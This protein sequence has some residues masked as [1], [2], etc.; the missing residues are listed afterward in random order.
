[1]H[2]L[3]SPEGVITYLKGTRFA[4]S[5]VHRL[6]GGVSAF[7]YRVLLEAPLDTGE[8]T[9]VIKHFEGYLANHEEMKWGIERADHEYKALAAI[10]NSGLFDSDSIVQLPRPLKYDQETHT[11]F[12]TDLGSPIPLTQVLEKGFPKNQTSVSTEPNKSPG[13][14]ELYKL[15]AEI[16]QALGDFLGRFHTW[17][18]LPQQTELRAYF[19]ENPGV[20]HKSLLFHHFCFN[21]SVDRFKIRE[22][23]M[24]G[25]LA[26]EQQ[27]LE[28]STD[29]GAMIMGDCSLHNILVSPPS[30][31]SPMRIYL[32]DLE[33]ARAG[34]P[35][36]D[37]GVLTAT[38]TSFALIYHPNINHPF[39][40]A[41]H[42][43]YRQHRTLDPRRL[44]ITTGID[45]LG[46]GTFMPWTRGRDEE[47][48]RDVA[49]AGF[50]LLNSS[51]TSD[52]HIITAN[53]IVQHLFSPQS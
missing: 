14:E 8:H 22:A 30:E 33:T 11:I 52:Q 9:I 32:I 45:L 44:G 21:F 43:S 17:S 10:N 47:S 18:A 25:V 42:E 49:T 51:V 35:E 13:L 37:I 36:F 4:A 40:P 24:N 31:T 28:A 3:K 29:P 19:L 5:S 12:M 27:E 6:V 38:A 7:T 46:L 39:V 20:V 23:W 15:A 1:M 26:K 48:L 16:G 53:R 50:E 2:D 34:H 41:L